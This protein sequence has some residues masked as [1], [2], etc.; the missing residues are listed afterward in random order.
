MQVEALGLCPAPLSSAIGTA[1]EPYLKGFQC[2]RLTDNEATM[3]GFWAAS[4]SLA[5]LLR[6]Q[7]VKGCSEW[8]MASECMT[9]KMAGLH[10]VTVQRRR[11]DRVCCRG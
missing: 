10:L 3:G 9:V 8:D 2:F 1:S 5:A 4:N 11:V 7:G 6:L